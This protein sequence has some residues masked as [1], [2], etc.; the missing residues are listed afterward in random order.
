VR[1]GF[2][3]NLKLA[4]KSIAKAL[5]LDFNLATNAPGYNAMLE[6][7]RIRDRITYASKIGR[8]L[9]HR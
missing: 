5:E 7:V 6:A 2:R 8:K 3:D 9:A 1:I 4:A